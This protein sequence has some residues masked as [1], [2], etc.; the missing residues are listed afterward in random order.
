MIIADTKPRSTQIISALVGVLIV[1][2][3]AIAITL[4]TVKILPDFKYKKTGRFPSGSY[5]TCAHFRF[6]GS[7]SYRKL[8]NY[9]TSFSL[10]GTMPLAMLGFSGGNVSL[11]SVFIM[12]SQLIF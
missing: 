2:N 9:I 4:F 7:A 6:G 5:R 8:N 3:V 12:L 1:R 11:I 10:F